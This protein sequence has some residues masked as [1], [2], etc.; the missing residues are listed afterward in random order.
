[1][2]SG[3]GGCGQVEVDGAL[4]LGLLCGLVRFECNAFISGSFK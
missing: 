4:E 2:W 3:G 1:M